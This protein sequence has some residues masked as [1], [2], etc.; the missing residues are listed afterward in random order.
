MILIILSPI[1]F[2]FIKFMAWYVIEKKE[3]IPEWLN[4]KPFNC[5]Q[6]CSFWTNLILSSTATY[7]IHFDFYLWILITLLDAVAYLIDRKQN[8][9]SIDDFDNE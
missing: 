1:L 5:V 3:W 8:T 6:C 2:F 9:V 7:F 4:Y